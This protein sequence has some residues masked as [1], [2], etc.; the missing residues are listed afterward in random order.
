MIES[1]SCTKCLTIKS[2]T[3]FYRSMGYYRSD[4]KDCFNAHCKKTQPTYKEKYPTKESKEGRREYARCYYAENREQFKKYRG[5]T[6]PV[7][8]KNPESELSQ[9]RSH[10]TSTETTILKELA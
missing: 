2:L 7:K 5:L 10:Q 6:T 3:E 9:L 4:C 8:K 1:K